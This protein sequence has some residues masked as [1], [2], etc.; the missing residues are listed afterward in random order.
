ME[1]RR[2]IANEWYSFDFFWLNK[3]IELKRVAH[4]CKGFLTGK[5]YPFLPDVIENEYRKFLIKDENER[6]GRIIAGN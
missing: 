4:S 6:L 2:F 1:E 5:D 3:K